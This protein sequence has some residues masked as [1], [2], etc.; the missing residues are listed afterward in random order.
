[1]PYVTAAIRDGLDT[2][3]VGR[4]S[5][6]R[7]M[8]AFSPVA[9]AASSALQAELLV[10]GPVLSS[11]LR[12]T[13][14]AHLVSWAHHVSSHGGSVDEGLRQVNTRCPGVHLLLF[15]FVGHRV[16]A[17]AYTCGHT[18]GCTAVLCTFPMMAHV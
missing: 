5:A 9:V 15:C 13:I 8:G 17:L 18:C 3:A 11:A 6:A 16:L 4:H 2:A 12:S 1:M 14:D 7:W 10:C